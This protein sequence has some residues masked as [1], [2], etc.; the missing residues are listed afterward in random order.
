MVHFCARITNDAN[1]LREEVVAVLCEPGQLR[2]IC[3]LLCALTRPK[4]AGN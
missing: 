4:S 2:T 3:L 1:V